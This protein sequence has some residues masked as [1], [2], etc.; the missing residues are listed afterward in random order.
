M[1]FLNWAES[2][3]KTTLTETVDYEGQKYL[4][5]YKE[6]KGNLNPGRI[7]ALRDELGSHPVTEELKQVVCRWGGNYKRDAGK[8]R[9]NI[10][11]FSAI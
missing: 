4:A 5:T 7:R 1:S 6:I 8:F 2:N 9:V 3:A 10:V 11:T